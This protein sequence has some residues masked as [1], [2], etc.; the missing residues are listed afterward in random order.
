MSAIYSGNLLKGWSVSVRA[1]RK[2][3]QPSVRVR[4]KRLVST[5]KT[6][7]ARNR[8]DPA[9]ATPIDAGGGTLDRQ[10]QQRAIEQIMEILREGGFHCEL[11]QESSH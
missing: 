2:A 11:L 6:S 4:A 9:T 10:D 8:L 1:V 5:P 7:V 3:D